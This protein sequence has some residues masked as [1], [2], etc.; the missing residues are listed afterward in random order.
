MFF[1]FK[2]EQ[3]TKLVT[4]PNDGLVLPGV[5]RSAILELARDVDSCI[6]IEERPIMI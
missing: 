5:T 3:G 6:L 2:D 4:H 1:V